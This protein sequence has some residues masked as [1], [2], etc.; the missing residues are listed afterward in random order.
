[1]SLALTTAYDDAVAHACNAP[2][3]LNS[4]PE[5]KTRYRWGWR[6]FPTTPI[7]ENELVIFLNSIA[8]SALSAA[9]SIRKDDSFQAKNRFAAPVDKHHAISLS[10]GPDGEDVR[11]NFIVLPLTAFSDERELE[12]KEAHVNFTAMLLAGESKS[13]HNARDGRIRVQRYMRRIERARPWLRFAIGMSVGKDFVALSRG[14]GSG[15][16][17]IE[18]SLTDGRG[19][20][21][22]IR[23]ILGIVVADKEAF[24]HNPEIDIEE[25]DVSLVVPELSAARPHTG[26][27]TATSGAIPATSSGGR[28]SRWSN[29]TAPSNLP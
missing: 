1:M 10:Y 15:L 23:T 16:E 9:R 7:D 14:D 12:V 29:P 11:A 2:P 22:F 5:P 4:T 6:E 3:D 27:N 19:C 17:R 28:S 24:G 20:I 18:I 21:E 8:D 25:R 26:T 13:A